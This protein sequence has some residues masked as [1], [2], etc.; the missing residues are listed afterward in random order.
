MWCCMVVVAVS[1]SRMEGQG[2]RSD[3]VKTDCAT[4]SRILSPLFQKTGSTGKRIKSGIQSLHLAIPASM[5]NLPPTQPNLKHHANK[6]SNANPARIAHTGRSQAELSILFRHIIRDLGKRAH[7]DQAAE[8][9]FPEDDD[10]D[11]VE[12]RDEV[13]HGMGREEDEVCDLEKRGDV[14]MVDADKGRAGSRDEDAD[15]VDGVVGGVEGP[16]LFKGAG[17]EGEKQGRRHA[18]V[19]GI[20]GNV[21]EEQREHAGW[22]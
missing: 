11:D 3:L 17:V 2:G 14:E 20:F 8:Q 18:L 13:E 12:M 10:A 9:T 15:L 21:D 5:V 1:T 16:V 7:I 19:D 4:A 22:C 6:P